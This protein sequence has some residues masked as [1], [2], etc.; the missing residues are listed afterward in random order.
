MTS[1]E[2]KLRVRKLR[3]LIEYHRTL[4]HTFDAPELSD[5]AFDALKNELEEL[6]NAYPELAKGTSPTQK[7]GGKPLEGFRKVPHEAPMWSLTDAFS[8]E[9]MQDWLERLR[10]Y[11]KISEQDLL[12]DGFYCELKID[13]LAVEFLYEKGRLVQASTRGDGRTGEDITQ[14]VLTIQS[15]PAAL[16]QLGHYKIPD[17]LVVRGEIYITRKELARINNEQEKAGEKLYA[18][19]RNLAAGSIRQLD[20]AVAASRAMQSFQYD[21]VTPISLKP[22]THEEKHRALASW[23]LTVNPHNRLARTLADALRFRDMWEGKR[24]AIP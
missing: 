6:E 10:N 11:L 21:I 15:I 18:N 19:A 16:E 24:N 1:E 3:G 14:N 5:A 8:A 13:G 9:E 2:L 4:Y 22:D 12:R 20:P 7:V 17:H 23:G